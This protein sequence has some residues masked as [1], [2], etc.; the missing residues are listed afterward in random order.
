MCQFIFYFQKWNKRLSHVL[1]GRHSYMQC[2]VMYVFLHAKEVL[3]CIPTSL[4]Y[5]IEITGTGQ[6]ICKTNIIWGANSAVRMHR[7]VYPTLH[8]C[9]DTSRTLQQSGYIH[10]WHVGLTLI[11]IKGRKHNQW[12]CP[13]T[14]EAPD[15]ISM[16]PV[17]RP[18]FCGGRARRHW[19]S[20]YLQ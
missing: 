19:W 17:N 18:S 2:C 8:I 3:Q 13:Q 20:G 9:P 15:N 5:Y 10:T 12:S 11:C 14:V 16:H 1:E 6:W 4:L 7:I